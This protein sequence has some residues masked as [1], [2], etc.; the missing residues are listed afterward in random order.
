MLVLGVGAISGLMLAAL[1]SDL[2]AAPQAGADLP[3]ASIS[4]QPEGGKDLKTSISVRP[5][6]TQGFYV[7]VNNPTES[8]QKITALITTGAKARVIAKS[9]PVTLAAG[10]KKAALFQFTE[11]ELKAA[12]AA[13][14]KPM[15]TPEAIDGPPFK[16]Q[17]VLKDDKNADIGKPIPV[18]VKML[19]PWDYLQN[20]V[21]KFSSTNERATNLWS[22]ELQ[23]NKT[24]FS[25]P[26]C[27]VRLDFPAERIPFLRKE[28]KPKKDATMQAKL[29]SGS[30]DAK[31][32]AENLTF[33]NVP[34]ANANGPVFVNVDGFER[35]FIFDT[36][37][38]K[39]GTPA[40]QLFNKE[41]VGVKGP[42]Y[43]RPI[44]YTVTALVDNVPLG[45]DVWV[46]LGIDLDNT[47]KYGPGLARQFHGARKQE[48]SIL[49]K[50]TDGGLMFNTIVK[51]WSDKWETPE[52]F[53]N[54]KI[55]ARL[56]DG[57]KKV[58]QDKQG[59]EMVAEAMVTF[60][61]NGPAGIALGKLPEKL[62]EGQTLTVSATTTDPKE[63]IKEV[64]FFIGKPETSEKDGK[65]VQSVPKT[66]S[67]ITGTMKEDEVTK[68]V[69]W[70]A[71]L[72]L[73]RDMIGKVPISV[74]FKNQVGMSSFQTAAVTVLTKAE[75][76]AGGGGVNT[77]S[78]KG[79]VVEGPRPQA[80]LDVAL[81]DDKTPG[82]KP[83]ATAKTNDKGEFEFKDVE[84]GSYTV[85][86]TKDASKTKG[87]AAVT[88]EKGKE[89]KV[90]IELFRK[91]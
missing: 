24:Y 83:K 26:E 33:D 4:D 5:N 3:T 70:T 66:A 9:L 43:S 32:F 79:T 35:A 23:L 56:L 34:D 84:P 86:T 81:K 48:I 87:D 51:D 67:K 80:G 13:K 30:P 11:E 18:D 72:D 62:V 53:G 7:I 28:I 8:E 1:G 50:S 65:T 22:V 55:R 20:P 54:R 85:S 49:P 60:V 89:A 58:K 38:V 21:A 73:S 37:F 6:V 31:L 39:E 16:F 36:T 44:D 40:P 74:E 45:D 19:S 17:I 25:G 76:N 71:D 12:E 29:S 91:P 63:L 52:V 59:R 90:A 42:R 57:K 69:S 75:A 27:P 64:V 61:D 46:E 82:N 68:A 14:T 47:G 10:K 77:G 2:P 41:A 15:Q 78:I 88:V